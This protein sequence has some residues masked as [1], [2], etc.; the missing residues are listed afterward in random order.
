MQALVLTI[1]SVV[2]LAPLAGC[3]VAYRAHPEFE[4][5]ARQIKSVA[6]LPPDVKV[7]E[8]SAGGV[9]EEMDPWSETARNN[10]QASLGKRAGEAG[11]F[12]LKEFDPAGSPSANQEFEDAR[13][14]FEAVTLST[15]LHAYGE[16]TG[17]T[18]DTKKERFEY[19]LGPLHA[20][21]DAAGTDA[22][23]FVY[24]RDNISSGG[25]VALRVLGFLMVPFTLR[26]GSV[27]IPDPGYTYMVTALVDCKTG[28]VLWFDQRGSSGGVDLRDPGSADGMVAEL[29]EEF[30]KAATGKVSS[31]GRDSP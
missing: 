8:L 22:L 2:L 6:L 24:A 23:L 16:Q 29:L 11:D 12:V 28:D 19:S 31:K 30:K 3:A 4:Q 5:R 18:F 7:Y 10:L 20:L 1:L 25:R 17:T 9:Q 27:L 21:A 26:L 13:P 15:L 14:L